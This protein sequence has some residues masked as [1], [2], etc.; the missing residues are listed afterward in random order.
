LFIFIYRRTHGFSTY[1]L[2]VEGM[3]WC[4]I[5]IKTNTFLCGE[6]TKIKITG[7]WKN[8]WTN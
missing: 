2:P 5:K 1:F 8:W 6:Q 3:H 7:W 4:Y